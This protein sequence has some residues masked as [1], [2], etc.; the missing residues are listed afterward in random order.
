MNKPRIIIADLDLNYILPLQLKFVE[1]YFDRIDLEV[2]TDPTYFLNL[3]SKPQK[4]D[5][6]IVS[7]QFFDSSLQMHRIS[8]IFLMAEQPEDEADDSFNVT[9]IFKYSN[10]KE[11]F[12]KIIGK[13]GIDPAVNAEK[14]TQVEFFHAANGG[15]GKTA[16]AL[17]VCASLVGNYKKVLYINAA[18]MQRFQFLLNNNTPITSQ[19]VYDKL[20][21]GSGDAYAA[22]KPV[23]RNEV[24]SYLP[25]FKAA[26]ISL[27]IPFSVYERIIRS[28]RE[29]GEYDYIVVDSDSPFDENLAQ[30]LNI[31]DKVIVVTKQTLPDVFATNVFVSNINGTSSEKYIFI[32]NNFDPVKDNYLV[33][34]DLK[35]KFTVSEYIGH[36]KQFDKLPYSELA[37]DSGIQKIAF[38]IL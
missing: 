25:P 37:A 20:A 23:I 34:N 11:I 38:L 17:A 35:L 26:L 22:I 28:A 13:S 21:Y 29:S 15:N 2:I 33:S 10:I 14:S 32:C 9:R 18:Y 24:F 4:A 12:N 3:F 16:L 8:D 30:L 7:E 27:G 19:D 31:S 5:I 36:I 6:L 1:E